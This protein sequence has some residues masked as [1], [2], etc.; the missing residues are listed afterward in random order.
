MTDI[1]LLGVKLD[2]YRKRSGDVVGFA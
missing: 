2:T 1:A